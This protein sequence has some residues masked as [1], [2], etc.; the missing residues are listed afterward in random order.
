[1][2]RSFTLDRRHLL[3]VGAVSTAVSMSGWM[4][5]LAQAAEEKKV[6]PKRSCILLWMN[7]GPS[8]IDLWDLKV[9]HENGGPYK[10]IEAAPDLKIGEHLPKLAK[11]GKQIAVLRGMSTKE[12]DHARGTYLM[13]TGQ[14]PGFAGIQYPSIG[15]LISKELGD[16]KAELPNF[17]SIAPQRFFAQE[18]F[19]PGFLGPVHAPL[20]VGDNQFNNGQ[21]Q[22]IDTILKVADL[23]KP[24]AIDDMTHTA[25]LEMLREMQEAFAADRPGM[26]SKSHT[27]A[28]D[29]AIR[30]MQS[31]GGKVFDLTTEKNEVRDKYGRNLFGQGCLLAR[32]LVEKG[33][34]FIEV[35]LG[36]WDTHGNNFELVKGL[37]GTLDTAWAALMDD[38]KDRGLLDTTTIVWMGEFG[39]TPKINQGRGRDHF[40]NA[41]STVI[42]GGGI[43]GG[44]AVGK[45][46]KD[47]TTVEERKTTTADFLATV[48]LAQGI[49]PEKTNMSNVNRPI[50]IVDRGAKPVTEVLQ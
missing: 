13:R 3:R 15:S 45:T 18:A 19:G 43:K 38:L 10:E 9:G 35:T 40:P 28:Y 46:S 33:V 2:S 25:R 4:G 12:G 49:D 29:R 44:Q 31:D 27:A 21:G 48:C 11:H 32:R 30:L 34:S 50:P 16:P 20:I 5:K 22:N 36:N 47:G 39:R 17:I 41:W 8:T 26:V 23:D 7:G 14:L 37:C 24:K 6:K 42:A 1:M